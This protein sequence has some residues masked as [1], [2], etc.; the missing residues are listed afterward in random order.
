MGVGVA[1]GRIGCFVVGLADYTYGTPTSLPWAWDFGDGVLRHPVQLYESLSLTLAMIVFLI[2][3]KLRPQDVVNEGFY[4]FIGWYGLQR[5]AFEFIKPYSDVVASLN[6]FHLG[7]IVLV[8]Y[9][10]FMIIRA[11]RARA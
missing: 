4:W 11:R 7:S 6:V 9:A 2:L 10:F 8:L 3:L 1:I 5:F